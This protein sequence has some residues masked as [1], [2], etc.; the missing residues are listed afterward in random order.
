MSF[1][2]THASK[3]VDQ[4][5]KLFLDISQSIL[6][7]VILSSCLKSILENCQVTRKRVLVHF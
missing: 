7:D 4:L 6:K 1:E 3:L 5:C 2:Y